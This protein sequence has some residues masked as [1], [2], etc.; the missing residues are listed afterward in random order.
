MLEFLRMPF[1]L[2][3]AAQTFQRFMNQVKRGLDLVFVCL[4]DVFIASRSPEEYLTYLKLLF[5]R[6]KDFGLNLNA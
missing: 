2:R 5:Q 4:D 1:G 6:V 3:N